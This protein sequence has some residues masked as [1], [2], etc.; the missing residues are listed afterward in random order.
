MANVI[1]YP[2]YIEAMKTLPANK[3][4]KLFWAIANRTLGEEDIPLDKTLSGMFSLIEPIIESNRKRFENGKKGGEFGKLG[5]RPK[6]QTTP[7]GNADKTSSEKVFKGTYTHN[8]IG[9]CDD[10]PSETPDIDKDTDKDTDKDKDTDID[11]DSDEDEDGTGSARAQASYGKAAYED[12]NIG[13]MPKTKTAKI[14]F[15]AVIGDYNSVCVS[16]PAVKCLTDARRAAITAR[17]AE[18][19]FEN[20]HEVFVKT[21]NSD[22]LCGRNRPTGRS[23]VGRGFSGRNSEEGTWRASFDWLLNK[24]NFVKVLEGNYDP[25]PSPPSDLDDLFPD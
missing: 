14:D 11:I 18:H 6:K 5:G 2:S 3:Q 23:S 19:G 4:I 21:E 12:G 10:E 16:L 24:A 8:P 9:V 17:I 13:S 22:F 7:D 15:R 1:F 20:L 25:K